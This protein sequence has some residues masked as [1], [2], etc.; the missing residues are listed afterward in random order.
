MRMHNAQPV[1]LKIRTLN[2]TALLRTLGGAAR[3]RAGYQAA[4]KVTLP[5]KGSAEVASRLVLTDLR[6]LMFEAAWRFL[7]GRREGVLVWRFLGG[8]REGGRPGV[9]VPRRAAYCYR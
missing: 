8:R 3:Y 7:G 2:T 4:H 6:P 5:P 1:P 9:A